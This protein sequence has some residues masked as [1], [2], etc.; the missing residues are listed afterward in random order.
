MSHGHAHWH[1]RHAF[2][3]RRLRRCPCGVHQEIATRPIRELYA[4]CRGWLVTAFVNG[5]IGRAHPCAR[6]RAGRSGGEDQDEKRGNFA[7][8]NET[9]FDY[10]THRRVG[11]TRASSKW[12]L[13][14]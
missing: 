13:A 11:I 8:H 1:E 5:L 7:R 10:T 3:R 9:T 14:H 6:Q 4:A 12:C 2:E